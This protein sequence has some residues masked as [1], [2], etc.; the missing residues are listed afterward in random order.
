MI[1]YDYLFIYIVG[2]VFVIASLCFGFK[3]FNIIQWII[4]L[5]I[6]TIINIMASLHFANRDNGD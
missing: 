5:C 4:T 1:D 6:G 3:T 2:L